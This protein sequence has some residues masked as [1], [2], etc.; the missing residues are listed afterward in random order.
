MKAINVALFTNRTIIDSPLELLA[1]HVTS[2]DQYG[3]WTLVIGHRIY[4]NLLQ[5]STYYNKNHNISL[6]I[7]S[8]PN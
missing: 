6:Y 2:N 1:S 4:G 5:N 8:F 3:H 7:T